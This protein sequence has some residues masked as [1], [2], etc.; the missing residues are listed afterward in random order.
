MPLIVLWDVDH[1]LIENCGVSKEIYAAAFTALTAREPVHPV[2]TEGRTD[3]LIMS[4]LLLRH[5]AEPPSWDVVERALVSAGAQWEAE[6]GRRGYV[7][8]GAREALT[9]LSG[10]RD[11]V[12]SVLTGN[13][14]ANAAAKLR[15]FELDVLVDLTVGAYGA[16]GEDR[17]RLVPVARR[18]IEAVYGLSSTTPVVLVG[19][20][21]RDVR[22]A[23][24]G[25]VGVVAVASGSYG[26]EQLMAAGARSV[27]PDLRDTSGLLEEIR[28]QALPLAGS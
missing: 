1:T 6:L 16:D 8:P 20:T 10:K 17:A 5:G 23:L 7:L 12:S 22:A 25:G 2:V 21:P 27:L 19:D 24:D 3:R 18:R 4:E 28:G 26:V 14:A 9:A 13:I 11:V 15:A